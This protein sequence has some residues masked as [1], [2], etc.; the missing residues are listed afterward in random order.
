MENNWCIQLS[1]IKSVIENILTDN[2]NNK[3]LLVG[4]KNGR[5]GPLGGSQLTVNHRRGIQERWIQDWSCEGEENLNIICDRIP[6][7][8][9]R[10]AGKKYTISSGMQRRQNKLQVHQKQ[11]ISGGQRVL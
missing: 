3:C 4:D 10:V 9:H 8:R 11:S 1:K 2:I 5:L 7:R 6:T